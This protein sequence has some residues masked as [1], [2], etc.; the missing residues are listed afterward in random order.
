MITLSH[1]WLTQTTSISMEPEDLEK[2]TDAKRERLLKIINA[3]KQRSENLK[4]ELI[5]RVGIGGPHG[6]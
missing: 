6:L 2:L 3:V 5:E 4:R 1:N